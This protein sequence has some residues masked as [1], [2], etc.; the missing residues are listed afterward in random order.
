[1]HSQYPFNLAM[2]AIFRDEA[3]YL[4]EWIEFHLEMGFERFYLFDNLS[5]DHFLEVLQPYIDNQIV[6]LSSWPI[7]HY[8]MSDWTEIQTLAYER[9]IHSVRGKVK[10]LAIL[11]T[12]EFLFP[13]HDDNLV[14]FLNRYDDVA[15][16]TINWQV[17]GTSHVHR[18]P[19]DKLLIEMLT[20]KLP[21]DADANRHIK[22]IVRPE[23]IDKCDNPHHMIY[24]P[25]YF[26]VNSDKMKFEGAFSP[27]IQINS[28]R[29]N[30]YIARDRHF[31]QTT[32]LPRRRKWI[33]DLNEFEQWCHS[34]NQVCDETVLRFVP[35]LKN[36][37]KCTNIPKVGKASRTL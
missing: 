29:I 7:E 8:R 28:V 33:G 4:K 11:D 25:G 2:A 14:D 17:F 13:V 22:S 20:L 18:I 12:D 21:E 34:L 32:K 5:T 16:L 10:W 23:Y 24:K 27:Y 9:A 1:M 15:G 19:E 37:R 3:L 31:T 30:H 26:Q 6:E 35:R 36:R